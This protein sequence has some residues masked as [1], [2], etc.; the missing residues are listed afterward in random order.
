MECRHGGMFFTSHGPWVM[1][2]QTGGLGVW[3][4]CAHCATC[5]PHLLVSCESYAAA[6]ILAGLQLAHIQLLSL[7]EV[8][9]DCMMPVL[10]LRDYPG[11]ADATGAISTDGSKFR[12][13]SG[14]GIIAFMYN[15]P[16][17]LTAIR[18]ALRWLRSTVGRFQV[19][20]GTLIKSL[21][22]R[23]SVEKYA[24]ARDIIVLYQGINVSIRWCPGHEGVEGNELADQLANAKE[25][26]EELTRQW[27]CLIRPSLGATVREFFWSF[28][29]L[30]MLAAS[31]QLATACA[32]SL[33]ET[34]PR[35][36]PGPQCPGGALTVRRCTISGIVRFWI[37]HV[38]RQTFMFLSI[39]TS[40]HWRDYGT[41][42]PNLDM[43]PTAAIVLR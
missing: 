9:R 27:W 28:G 34:R 38:K 39:C 12:D 35:P 10:P 30:V 15:M 19:F 40:S 17:E 41:R 29:R 2:S 37:E 36:A 1:G 32:D 6:T 21:G 8:Q 26:K 14:G 7:L 25:K 5:T 24:L 20:P 23:H 43:V 31:W 13:G 18:D 16:C 4:G 42:I 33:H 3:Y 11:N 22:H